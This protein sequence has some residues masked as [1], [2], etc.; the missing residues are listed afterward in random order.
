MEMKTV[1][2]LLTK[3]SNCLGRFICAI[4]KNGYSHASISIDEREEIFYSFNYKGFVIEKPKKYSPGKRMPGSV[5]IRMQVLDVSEEELTVL[6]G[7]PKTK[8]AEPKKQSGLYLSV[9]LGR[10]NR[11]LYRSHRN[12]QS[13]KNIVFIRPC[14]VSGI[15][16]LRRGGQ[17]I[18]L[19]FIYSLKGFIKIVL[20]N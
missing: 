1:T 14:G 2:I 10:Q 6:A 19:F 4:S 16:F 3:Y 11:F 15:P 17:I 9:E 8:E 20:K 13:R 18:L 5:Y 12:G 7:P